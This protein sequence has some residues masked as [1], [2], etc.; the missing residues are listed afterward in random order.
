MM[1]LSN[2]ASTSQKIKGLFNLNKVNKKHWPYIFL[3]PFFICY[4][5]FN[6]Y[7]V[8]FSFFVSLTNWDIMSMGQTKFIGLINYIKLVTDD[9]Y[10]IKSVW[11]T[12]LFMIG[13]IPISL[14]LGLLLAVS[15]FNLSKLKKTFQTLNFLP[16]IT[17]P[18]AIGFIFSFL[19]N[20]SNGLINRLLEFL[21]L[22]SGGINWL[23]NPDLARIVVILMIFW[24]NFGYYFI[25]YLA[26]LT[27]LPAE[28]EEAATVDGASK[29]Q[30]FYYITLPLLKPITLFLVVTS[31]IGGFQLFAEPMMLFGGGLGGGGSSIVGGPGR[32]ALTT[33]WYFYDTA[34]SNSAKLGYG[35]AVSYT[36]FLFIMVFSFI[37]FKLIYRRED[38]K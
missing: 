17:T 27:S 30:T 3:M 10:F 25:V 31:I 4:F 8:L 2:Q 1:T 11:N 23:G 24:K 16:Y 37:S 29:W 14:I 22:I 7:P 20:W 6:L 28:L 33:I 15:I 13:Y 26:G 32:T 36:L 9:P 38:Q 35:A 5:V 18:V 19:F 34:F 21:G 12:I